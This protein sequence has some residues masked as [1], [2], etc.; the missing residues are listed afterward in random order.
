MQ[1]QLGRPGGLSPGMPEVVPSLLTCTR[2]LSRCPTASPKAL[3]GSR[4]SGDSRGSWLWGPVPPSLHLQPLVSLTRVR[5]KGFPGPATL[6]WCHLV[7]QSP[8]TP[9]SG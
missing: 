7:V 1:E 4:P 3:Q 5:S 8:G 6:A 2:H 9:V